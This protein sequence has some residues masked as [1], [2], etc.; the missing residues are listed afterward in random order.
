[1]KWA[2]NQYRLFQKHIPK[3]LQRLFGFSW[4]D[5][6]TFKLR[7]IWA[8]I[9]PRDPYLSKIFCIFL[10]HYSKKEFQDHSGPTKGTD[11]LP[12]R[13]ISIFFLNFCICVLYFL[14]IWFY[15]P[16]RWHYHF[17]FLLFGFL[18]SFS[19]VKSTL[20]GSFCAESL[21]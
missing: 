2:D 4:C 8:L 20:N 17:L 11:Y 9:S 16:F 5:I 3:Q 19:V 21:T 14:A 6:N 12:F 10:S 7:I 1:M 18:F 13:Y 15:F